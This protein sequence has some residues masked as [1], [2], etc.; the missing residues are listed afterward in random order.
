MKIFTLLFAI[1]SATVLAISSDVNIPSDSERPKE[2][3]C[4]IAGH[5]LSDG[6]GSKILA[7]AKTKLVYKKADPQ[8]E[9]IAVEGWDG[10]IEH[11]HF[12]SWTLNKSKTKAL[13]LSFEASKIDVTNPNSDPSKKFKATLTLKP[14]MISYFIPN[15]TA[16][17]TSKMWGFDLQANR[18]G[19]AVK[20]EYSIEDLSNGSTEEYVVYGAYDKLGLY[21]ATHSYLYF[22]MTNVVPQPETLE[23]QI[24][25][26]ATHSG[27]LINNIRYVSKN[28]R[29]YLGNFAVICSIG[30]ESR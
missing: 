27:A 10:E 12:I 20:L 25:D 11:E 28:S 6:R 26:E 4:S 21:E 24:K 9:T 14:S 23:N 15:P 13:S 19:D 17:E 3:K 16:F 1:N 8:V 2:L 30:D 7:Q 18:N 29:A 22:H 5:R